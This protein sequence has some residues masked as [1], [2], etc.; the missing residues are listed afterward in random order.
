MKAQAT[1]A[2]ILHQSSSNET[3]KDETAKSETEKK[4]G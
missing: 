4:V 3:E 2:N 1:Q